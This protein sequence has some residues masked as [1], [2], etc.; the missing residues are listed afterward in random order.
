MHVNIDYRERNRLHKTANYLV[1]L[2][3]ETR[4][5]G[6]VFD[7]QRAVDPRGHLD[8]ARTICHVTANFGTTSDVAEEKCHLKNRQNIRW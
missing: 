7:A 6:V 2:D 5:H 1:L 8:F 4:L 3:I